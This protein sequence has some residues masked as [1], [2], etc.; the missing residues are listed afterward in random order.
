MAKGYASLLKEMYTG[1]S[2]SS[3]SP[4]QFKAT[5]GRH[6]TAFSG[7]GQQDS[8]EFLLFLLDG[9]QEDLNRIHKK[10]Y[11]EKPDSTDEMVHDHNALTAMAEK[12]WDIYKARNDSVITD[13][14][15]GMYKSTLVCPVC[16]KVSIIFDPFNNLTL[17]LPVEN[18]W[19]R[20]VLVFP[21]HQR[22][23][24]IAIDL[25]TNDTF[26]QLK[27]YVA[28]KIRADP[29]RLVTSEIYKFR[30]FKMF[31]DKSTLGEERIVHNDIVALFEVDQI[32]TNY[33]LKRAKVRSMLLLN[34]SEDENDVPSEG[35]DSPMAD[36]ILMPVFNRKPG[37]A[38]SRFHSKLLFGAPF[39]IVLDRDDTR[40]KDRI[41]RKVLI[42]LQTLTTRDLLDGQ[43]ED[44]RDSVVMN[45]DESENTADIEEAE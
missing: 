19:T 7:Y 16:A 40:D 13:L 6:N 43:N 32:P 36:R 1:S 12:C 15:A 11:I 41:L 29:R 23:I 34:G 39:Y 18:P 44:D 28:K 35:S 10:P 9:L 25:A 5:V 17:Q 3:F 37:D 22:P 45:T 20:D 27:E 33:P 2:S 24:V 14:F 21:L 4:R 30:F 31:N 8:Q 38:S 26:Y 42:K